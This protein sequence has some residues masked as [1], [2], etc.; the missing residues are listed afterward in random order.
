MRISQRLDKEIP[1]REVFTRPQLAE[2]AEFIDAYDA[3]VVSA[4]IVAVS[5]DTDLPLS[6][7]QLRLWLLDQIDGGSVHYNVPFALRLKGVLDVDA[8]Q[9]VFASII[10]RHEVLRTTYRAQVDGDGHDEAGEVIQ[11]IHASVPVPFT[12][13]DLRDEPEQLTDYLNREATKPFDLSRDAMLRASLLHVGEAEY[14]LSVTMH[15]IASDGWSIGA[16]L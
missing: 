6:F 9:K 15:H 14:V 16:G 2:Q 3:S 8:L 12:E 1:L 4:P 11:V 7:A 13:H 5:R 10:E